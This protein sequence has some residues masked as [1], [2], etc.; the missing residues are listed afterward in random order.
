MGALE[1]LPSPTRQPRANRRRTLRCRRSF[2]STTTVI[3]LPFRSSD[4]PQCRAHPAMAQYLPTLVLRLCLISE[5]CAGK[6][7]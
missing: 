1:E 4:S 2:L 6:D 3:L 7:D 5:C